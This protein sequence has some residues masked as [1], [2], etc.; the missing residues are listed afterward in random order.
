[1]KHYDKI[2]FILG[3]IACLAGVGV[4][5]GAKPETKPERATSPKGEAF[6]KWQDDKTFAAAP[7]KWENPVLD[8]ET[9]WNYDLFSTPETTWQIGRAHV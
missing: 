1:M 4:Y 2:V 3:L 8:M 6:A 7:A 9:G 5:L